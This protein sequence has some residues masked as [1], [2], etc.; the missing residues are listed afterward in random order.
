MHTTKLSR[1]MQSYSGHT[2][3][4]TM[5]A[6]LAAIPET[7]RAELTGRQLALWP[8]PSMTPT[9]V[10]RRPLAPKLSTRRRPAARCGWTRLTRPSNGGGPNNSFYQ[11]EGLWKM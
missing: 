2:G 4:V 6:V 10:A 1:L 3:P 5:D 8:A 9:T 11:K 7:L